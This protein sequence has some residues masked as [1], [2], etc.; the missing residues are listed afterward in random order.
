MVNFLWLNHWQPETGNPRGRF[1]FSQNA[2]ALRG[3]QSSNF[4]NQYAAFLLGLVGSTSDAVN[5]SVQDEEMTGREWQHALYVRDRW[6]LSDKLTLDLGLRW[7]YYPIMQ[8]ENHG[9]ERLDYSTL[10]VMIGGLGGVP[11]NVGL[12]ASWDNFAPRLGAIY[13]WNENTVLRSGYG[14][15]YNPIP[16]ARVL[17]GD[18]IYPNVIAATFTNNEQFGWFSTIN[19]GIPNI[20]VPDI[21]SGKVKLPNAPTMWTPEVGNVDRSI[22]HSWNVAIERRLPWNLSADIAYV[23]TKL[24]GGYA[25]LDV[26]APTTLG[27]G[28]ASRPYAAMGRTNPILSWGQR[29][30]TDYQ[31]LQ[32]ALNR[33]FTKGL[34]LKGAYTLGEAFNMSQ[35]DEDG[36]VTLHRNTPSQ[37]EWNYAH[38]GYDKR[39]NLQVGFMYQL[40]WQSGT[41]S[42]NPVRAVVNDWELAGTFALFSG[43]PFNVTAN[44]SALNTPQNTQNADQVADPKHV[45]EIGGSGL[46]YD[47]SSWAQPTGVRFGTAER[48]SVYGPGGVNLDLSINRAFKFGGNK[49]IEFRAVGANI[50]NTPKFANPNGDITSVNFMRV[51]ANLNGYAERN[52]QL[53]LRFQF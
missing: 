18:N 39:H 51:T 49:Q 10:E 9:L 22:I 46:Y 5:K 37:Y 53:G 21:S 8:R 12:E 38:A 47:P 33:P 2:T 25:A 31:S 19:Q 6:N 34:L 27:G 30:R 7:E 48:N 35:N 50:T 45:G 24:V 36:R 14:L 11:Q 32:I 15:T 4:Y 16:W 3:G 13:R 44:G 29:L 41:G 26:N 40:P 52:F 17:R 42:S 1:T 23:G 28:N 20:T 43:S